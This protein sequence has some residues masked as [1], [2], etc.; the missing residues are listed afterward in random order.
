MISAADA[1]RLP[2]AQL[3]A[4][5]ESAAD[6]LA[7]SIEE[8]ISAHM[9]RRGVDLRISE[10]RP[11]VIAEV[12]QRLMNAGWATQWKGLQSSLGQG[13][14]GFSLALAPTADA[15]REASRPGL[16]S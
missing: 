7:A 13:L 1:L 6:A 4:S 12:N 11:N 5:E 14:T 3:S 9:E 8:H 15:Y 10:T 16:L 2:C